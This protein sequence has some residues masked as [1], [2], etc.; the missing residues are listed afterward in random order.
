MTSTLYFEKKY[1]VN[2]K[3][4]RTTDDIDHIIEKQ[5]GQKIQV[6]KTS[7]GIVDKAGKVC[8][9]LSFNINSRIDAA[10]RRK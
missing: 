4:I 2:F 10:L 6:S 9:V 5:S 3:D 1:G 8:S 7:C